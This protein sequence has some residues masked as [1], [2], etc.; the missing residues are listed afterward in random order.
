M[1][2]MEKEQIQT[3]T[4]SQVQASKMSEIKQVIILRKDLDMSVGKVAAQASHASLA[5]YEDS[6]ELSGYKLSALEWRKGSNTKVA[7][8]VHSEDEL[9]DVFT[10]AYSHDLP[11]H[12]V[13]DEGRTELKGKNFTAVAIGPAPSIEINKITGHLKLYR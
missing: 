8:M 7:L 9:I 2:L 12:M 1:H 4:Q 11:C 10:E 6:L 3:L 13:E 5:S